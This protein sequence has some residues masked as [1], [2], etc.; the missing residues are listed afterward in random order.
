MEEDKEKIIF[1]DED[2]YFHDNELEDDEDNF[3]CSNMCSLKLSKHDIRTAKGSYPADSVSQANWIVQYL[4]MHSTVSNEVS[5]GKVVMKFKNSF[6]ICGKVVCE[7]NWREIYGISDFRFK[8]YRQMCISGQTHV[9][10]G[11]SSTFKLQPNS[12]ECLGWLLNYV[13]SIGEHLPNENKIELPAGMTKR[14]VFEAMDKE[15]GIASVPEKSKYRLWNKFCSNV[16]TTKGSTFSK[17]HLCITMN[18]QLLKSVL[19]KDHLKTDLLR[20]QRQEHWNDIRAERIEY[21]KRRDFSR[22]DPSE[23]MCI[24][25]DAMDQC[26]TALPILRRRVSKDINS[27]VVQPIKTYLTGALIHRQGNSNNKVGHCYFDFTQYCH[28]TNLNISVLMEILRDYKNELGNQLHL[29]MDSASNNKNSLMIAFGGMLVHMKIFKE[30]VDAMFHNIADVLKVDVFTFPDLK[31]QIESISFIEKVKQIRNIWDVK[32][33]LEP[34]IVGSHSFNDC[35][36]IH[37]HYNKGKI[38]WHYKKWSKSPWFPDT[39]NSNSYLDEKDKDGLVI[40]KVQNNFYLRD[41]PEDMPRPVPPSWNSDLVRQLDF[42]GKK[43]IKSGLLTVE[44]EKWWSD[45]SVAKI[46]GG[47]YENEIAQ[48]PL[49]EIIE[50]VAARISPE[51]ILIPEE[52]Q[53]LQNQQKRV[54]VAYS[55]KYIN[56]AKRAKKNQED[57]MDN[58]LD[59]NT[60][61]D[62]YVSTEAE[63]AYQFPVTTKS[64]RKATRFVTC[65]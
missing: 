12:S 63:M 17:C 2:S 43:L 18:D 21:Y 20:A 27:R 28:D 35:F 56:P 33:W 36:H 9:I 16:K 39:N 64:G 38:V 52:I 45:L 40:F 6:F 8:K 41:F 24:I 42:V 5:E 34:F 49:L 62:V 61:T 1:P 60:E 48:C 46:Q 4:N 14:D 58:T 59:L 11:N 31:S 57:I 51:E 25:I 22:Q 47:D 10:H 54:N 15:L 7:K 37:V 65:T 32:K 30:D 13:S 44:E 3:C 19:I 23:M 53:N 26:K 55:G 50:T 29:Q